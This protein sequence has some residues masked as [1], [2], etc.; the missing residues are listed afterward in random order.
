MSWLSS[1]TRMRMRQV[2]EGWKAQRVRRRILAYAPRATRRCA[3]RKQKAQARGLAWAKEGLPRF[4][5]DLRCLAACRVGERAQG[6]AT[7]G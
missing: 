2:L 5:R 6:P 4:G 7:T 3:R 1:I